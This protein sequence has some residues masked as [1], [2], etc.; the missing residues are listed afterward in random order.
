MSEINRQM[1]TGDDGRVAIDD[2]VKLETKDKETKEEAEKERKETIGTRI[3]KDEN[4]SLI[5]KEENRR[6]SSD[7]WLLWPEPS[8]RASMARFSLLLK[9]SGILILLSGRWVPSPDQVVH[10]V[11][12]PPCGTQPTP[13][14]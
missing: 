12:H 9:Y 8:T 7:F 10:Q 2:E 4:R 11:N 6:K 3:E 5:N 1:A 13:P 14:S